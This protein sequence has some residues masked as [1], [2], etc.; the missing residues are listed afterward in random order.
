M[1]DQEITEFRVYPSIGIAQQLLAP[2]K[3]RFRYRI[4]GLDSD[5]VKSRARSRSKPRAT[6]A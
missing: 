3:I 6:T 2:E 5:A 4:S 1:S